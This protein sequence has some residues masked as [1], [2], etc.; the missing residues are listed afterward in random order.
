MLNESDLHILRGLASGKTQ[1]AI[2]A[3]LNMDQSAVSKLLRAAEERCGVGLVTRHGRRVSLTPHGLQIARA[4]ENV[5]SEFEI[6]DRLIA[7]LRDGSAGA[8]RIFAAAE[9]ADYVLPPLIAEF[10]KK[11]PGTH[12][13]LQVA[14]G[15]TAPL[16]EPHLLELFTNGRFDAAVLGDG[17]P[18]SEPLITRPLYRDHAVLFVGPGHPLFGESRRDFPEIADESLVANFTDPA[19]LRILK[20]EPFATHCGRRIDLR[21]D[22]AVKRLVA[23]G[24]GLGLLFCTAVQDELDAGRLHVVSAPAEPEWTRRF[25]LVHHAAA[26]SSP[27]AAN[28][29]RFLEDSLSEPQTA[30]SP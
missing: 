13:Q 11:V 22:E 8:I 10:I 9:P 14:A 28:V 6:L 27:L 17:I 4:S 26:S 23:Q 3:E 21:T 18:F 16:T 20:T 25:I 2:G 19:Y 29:R 24:V 5:L 30:A 7:S 12:V 15:D 1:A